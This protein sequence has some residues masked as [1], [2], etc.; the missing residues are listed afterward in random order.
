MN[1]KGDLNNVVTAI[2]K[3]GQYWKYGFK[4]IVGCYAWR[5]TGIVHGDENKE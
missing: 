2:M 5:N 3:T 1:S 4:K